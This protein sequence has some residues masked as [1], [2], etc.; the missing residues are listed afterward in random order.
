MNINGTSQIIL[1][2]S[3][4]TPISPDWI[5][6]FAAIAALVVAI[7]IAWKQISIQKEQTDIAEKQIEISRQQLD[8]LNYQEQ[9]RRKEKGKA[10]LKAEFIEKSLPT[11][12]IFRYSLRIQNEGKARARD[13]KI[14]IDDKPAHEYFA[15][16]SLNEGDIPRTL[17]QGV[18]WEYDMAFAEGQKPKFVIK[19]SWSDDS[20]E[21]RSFDQQ[22]LPVKETQIGRSWS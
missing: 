2:Q 7:I 4:W 17:E 14:L 8:I 21:T 18:L 12:R 13:I 9:E 3:Q 20:G 1:T 15:F 6:A 5:T 11:S 10:E 16:K 19:I 22:L